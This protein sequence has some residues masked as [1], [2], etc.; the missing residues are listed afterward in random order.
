MNNA[1]VNV[2]V[3]DG[4]LE[5]TTRQRVDLIRHV[6]DRRSDR[7]ILT[8]LNARMENAERQGA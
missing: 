1:P 5:V 3:R 4:N 8:E 7:G 2:D 6:F